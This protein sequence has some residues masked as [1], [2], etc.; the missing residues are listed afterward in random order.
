MDKVKRIA[1]TGVLASLA[2]VLAAFESM[3]P[4]IPGYPPGAKLGL[5]NIAV[6]FAASSLGLPTA[7]GVALIKGCF[8]FLTRGLTAGVMS[9]LGGLFSTLVM[10]LCLKKTGFSLI[11]T[12][13][14]G[15]L[16]HNLAQLLAAYWL[17]STSVLFYIPPMLILGI[18]SGILTG[19]VLRVI[20]P[21]LNRAA[22][23][24]QLPMKKP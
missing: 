2:L 19:A 14:L 4:P 24:F 22:I 8:A 16:T 15:A 6:M 7:V 21:V 20:L 10:W 1:F 13:V 23:F 9:L 5:S 3:L 11:L 17:T 18:L 12:G